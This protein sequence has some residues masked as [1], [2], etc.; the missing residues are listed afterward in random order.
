MPRFSTRSKSRLHT[1]DERL[2]KL[3]NEVV[4]HFDCTI[5]E[6]H[7]EKRS[8]MK[9]IGRG[10]VNLSSLMVSIIKALVLLL[11]LPPIL[12]IG[13]TGIGFII[14]AVSCLELL[15]RWD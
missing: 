1:C 2:V 15:S 13:L 11:M 10:I 9:R 7:R 4:K 3:F 14:L 12:L 8:R 6:G 5:I